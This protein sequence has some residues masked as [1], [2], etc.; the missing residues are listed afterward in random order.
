MSNQGIRR[1][2]IKG[3][4]IFRQGERGHVMYFIL[5]GSIK[6]TQGVRGKEKDLAILQKGSFFGE[7]ALF[8]NRLRSA[9]AMAVEVC[10][11]VEVDSDQLDQFLSDQPQVMRSMVNILAARLRET[12]DLLE[13]LRLDDSD[14]R[15][16]NA[17]LQT[18]EEQG[19]AFASV[20][21]EGDVELLVVK[22]TLNR[23]EVKR[24]LMKLKKLNLIQVFDK[25]IHIPSIDMLRGY[26]SYLGM[27]LGYSEE[28]LSK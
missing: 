23:D 4:V 3:E 27:R 8:T 22:T 10:Q 16:C 2:F 25:K 12:D 17:L 21:I 1:S 6:I 5:G 28:V 13:N 26:K 9:S 20:D 15:V 19:G 7:L 14:S 18:A 11:L 24:I